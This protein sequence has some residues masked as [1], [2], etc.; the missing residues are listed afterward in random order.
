MACCEEGYVVFRSG[1]LTFQLGHAGIFE[2][3]NGNHHRS[4]AHG[5]SVIEAMSPEGVQRTIFENFRSYRWT[6]VRTKFWGIR[7]THEGI[8]RF[9]QQTIVDAARSM[10]GRPYSFWA[11]N[12]PDR[13]FRCDGLVDYVYN[14]AGVQILGRHGRRP[15]SP[16]GQ[17]AVLACVP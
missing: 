6:I 14:Q 3:C 13:G 7:T 2:G 9:Q 8:T 5:L 1:V 11:Y 12:S 4:T 16:N 15:I 10:I 17:F